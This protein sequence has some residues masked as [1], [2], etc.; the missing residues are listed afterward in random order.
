[1]FTLR[2]KDRVSTKQYSFSFQKRFAIFLFLIVVFLIPP[3]HLRESLDFQDSKDLIDIS[4]MIDA[5]AEHREVPLSKLADALLE[6]D[7]KKKDLQLEVKGAGRMFFNLE[8]KISIYFGLHPLDNENYGMYSERFLWEKIIKLNKYHYTFE[9]KTLVTNMKASGYLKLNPTTDKKADFN[10]TVFEDLG[11][12]FEEYR[13]LQS[14]KA[15]KI[16]NLFKNIN[17]GYY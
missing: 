8:E 4:K 12:I 10:I 17:L 11:E 16:K 1:M 15:M 5:K 9:G 6:K 7:A 13:S 3:D 14:D 2:E